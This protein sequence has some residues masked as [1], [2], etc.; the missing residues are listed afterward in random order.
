MKTEHQC[1]IFTTF[2]ARYRKGILTSTGIVAIIAAAGPALAQQSATTGEPA[3]PE[4]MIVV[5]GSR[6]ARTGFDAPTP[7]SVITGAEIAA[8]APANI[9]D[10][11][12][13][14]PSV[15]GSST[16]AN[17]SGSLSN[18]LAGIASVNL[19][20]LGPIRTLVLFDGQRSVASAAN[21]VVDVNT[22]PQMLVERVEVVTG[23]ASS[24]YG[25]DA[26]S[27]VVNFILDK[28]LQGL[29]ANYE[30]GVT[31]YGDGVNDKISL[32]AGH[33]FGDDR[34]HVLVGG[35][36]FKQKGTFSID[37][38]WADV[39]YYQIDNPAYSAAA[40]ATT[41]QCLPA[42]LVGYGY[43]QGN[44][45]PGGLITSG[46]LRGTYFGTIDPTTGKAVTGTAAM[47][48]TS[49]MWMIGG[50]NAYL[51]SN[52][53]SSNTLIPEEERLSFLGRVSW[54]F[55]PAFEL[56]GQA[57]YSK[58]EGRSFYIQSVSSDVAIQ[59]DNAYLPD[60]IRQVMLDNNLSS[61]TIGTGNAGIAPGG[62]ANERE[63]QR[64][65]IGASGAF[66]MGGKSWNW[67]AY[68]QK[69]VTK[70]R[71]QLTNTWNVARM[72]K[73]TDAVV[74]Q[75]GNVGG[76][77]PGTIVCRVNVDAIATN[78]D[79]ACVPINRLGIGGVTDA[80]I[81]YIMN[82][83]NQPLRTQ[84]F[85]QDVAAV[86]LSTAN[87]FDLWA[88]P[89]SLAIGA[90][91][92]KESIDGNVD[93][94]FNSGW[95]YGN[96]LV[97]TG[98]YNVKEAYAETVVPLAKGLDFNGAFRLTDYSTSGTVTTWKTGL[99][100]QVIP[101]IRLRGTYSRDIRAPNLSELYAAPIGRTNTVNV[102]I[103]VNGQQAGVRSDE[104]VEQTLGNVALKPE[105]ATSWG[106]GAVFTPSF[107]PRF[108][109]SID[110]Y[111]VDLSGAVGSVGAQTT[112]NLCYE[113]NIQQYCNQIVYA[114]SSTTDIQNIRLV[115]FNFASIKTEGI[116]FEASYRMPVGPGNLTLRAL[117]T[118]YISLYTNNGVDV[119]TQQAGQ[120]GGIGGNF[121]NGTS[122]VPDWNFRFSANYDL[123]A[124]SFG[125]VG[126]G[127][128]SG[129]IDNSFIV[130]D[131]SC[132]VSTPANRTINK[133]H[134]SGA[135]YFD[136]N[137][138]YKFQIGGA[139]PEAFISV[140]NFL[141]RDPVLVGNGPTGNHITAYPNT[142]RDI[143]DVLGRVFRMGV[144]LAL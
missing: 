31:T 101:D 124:F 113:E 144:R 115:P 55:S 51:D 120:N 64:Y 28:K 40:C 12:N 11:V 125:V 23:G 10:F 7:V 134:V 94:Q 29:R 57:S 78:N 85:K 16:S 128:S 52:H 141:N 62:N 90:E 59:Q 95:L 89:I 30:H 137:A 133:N 130:C 84:T 56:F 5:T 126:R 47:G 74:A 70:V 61:I 27:G 82:D 79:S 2:S 139:K 99:T 69:G 18:G 122:N 49:G 91:Y 3:G 86:N 96:Y 102:P 39:N 138:S 21:G 140:T 131:T 103:M 65:V 26:V 66:D 110:Y 118:H 42:R 43:G 76:Y 63:V 54:E 87:L 20:A 119:P 35:E 92:R 104:F 68:Y 73:A 67:D 25:S 1:G 112:V 8:E 107:L 81:N 117:A 111:N 77:A 98:S 45:A 6:I 108:A 143:Y 127:V 72:N 17:S 100:W 9:A 44:L 129:V 83:G 13:T 53:K 123:D 37:R 114:A 80:A 41:S 38:P 136:V 135:F 106:L 116:D 36:Y 48:P 4:D 46:P 24:A 33:R 75:E 14:L 19:R 58:Y 32:A 97:T 142:N 34:G 15:R 109:A 22:I 60:N 121:G 93:P 88:G 132:P 50:D 105:K 71:E